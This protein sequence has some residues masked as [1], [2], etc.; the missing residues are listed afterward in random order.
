VIPV[1]ALLFLP[2]PD[3]KDPLV[4][5]VHELALVGQDVEFVARRAWP[6]SM[7]LSYGSYQ[8]DPRKLVQLVRTSK[9]YSTLLRGVLNVRTLATYP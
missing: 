1:E 7:V 3:Q 4:E 2:A 9:V 5:Y 6:E 8:L